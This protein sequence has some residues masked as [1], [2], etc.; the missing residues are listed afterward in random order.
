VDIQFKTKD[1]KT[2][3]DL[4]NMNHFIYIILDGISFKLLKMVTIG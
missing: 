1:G 3:V 2:V 4:G